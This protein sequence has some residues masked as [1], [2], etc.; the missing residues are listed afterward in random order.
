MDEVSDLTNV[1]ILE[2]DPEEDIVP[3]RENVENLLL[4]FNNIGVARVGKLGQRELERVTKGY[5]TMKKFRTASNS[6]PCS[7]LVDEK[8]LASLGLNADYVGALFKKP[9]T[10]KKTTTYISLFLNTLGLSGNETTEVVM[11]FYDDAHSFKMSTEESTAHPAGYEEIGPN[12][13][14]KKIRELCSSSLTSHLKKKEVASVIETSRETICQNVQDAIAAPVLDAETLLIE[15]DIQIQGPLAA[16]QHFEHM[17]E[18]AIDLLD[19]DVTK[20]ERLLRGKQLDIPGPRESILTE[21]LLRLLLPRRFLL[22]SS[23]SITCLDIF[24]DVLLGVSVPFKSYVY[25]VVHFTSVKGMTD[26]SAILL[27]LNKSSLLNIKKRDNS[28][29]EVWLR[30][31]KKQQSFVLWLEL[32]RRIIPPMTGLAIGRA[33]ER[34]DELEAKTLYYYKGIYYIQNNGKIYKS[35]N[36]KVAVQAVWESCQL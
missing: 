14:Q 32:V 23:S 34:S 19:C 4:W 8:R 1:H 25:D 30:E 7:A 10:S 3:D 9:A 28:L 16:Y 18:Q 33:D 20:L 21:E 17:T 22:K 12:L 36:F 35:P 6:L 24:L 29:P 2:D 27:M 13:T 5:E 11:R 15:T 26:T 31:L